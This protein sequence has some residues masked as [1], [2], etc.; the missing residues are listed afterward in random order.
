MG[1]F[2]CV[3]YLFPVLHCSLFLVN[4]SAGDIPLN[5]GCYLDRWGLRF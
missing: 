3:S 5:A 2:F 4:V 1:F